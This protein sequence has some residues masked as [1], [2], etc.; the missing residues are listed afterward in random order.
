MA[1]IL[2][3][4]TPVQTLI[5]QE[6]VSLVAVKTSDLENDVGHYRRFAALA[7]S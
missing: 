4:G 1:D 6:A 2:I 7:Q 5:D 3:R